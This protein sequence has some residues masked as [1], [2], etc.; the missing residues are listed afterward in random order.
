LD[1]LFEQLWLGL[2]AA[3]GVRKNR[4]GQSVVARRVHDDLGVTNHRFRW[5]MNELVVLLFSGHDSSL[6]HI[7]DAAVRGGGGVEWCRFGVGSS[8]FSGSLVISAGRSSGGAG[9]GARRLGSS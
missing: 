9:S 1:L 8:G 5:E 6:F 4:S 7:D 3:L 2:A